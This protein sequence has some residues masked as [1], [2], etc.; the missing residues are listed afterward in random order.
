M[1]ERVSR[2][3]GRGPLTSHAFIIVHLSFVVSPV[4]ITELEAVTQNAVQKLVTSS[5]MKSVTRSGTRLV[6]DKLIIYLTIKH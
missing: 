3:H 5:Q 6:Y 4:N 1:S 2:V